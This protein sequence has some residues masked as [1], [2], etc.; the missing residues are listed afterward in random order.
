MNAPPLSTLGENALLA[1]LLPGLPRNAG[2]LTGPGD[3]CAVVARNAA[4]DGLLK[5]DALVEGIHF[6]PGTEPARIGHKA[7]AR[8]LSDIAAMGGLPE[9][10]LV[11]LF[12]HPSRPVSLIE[13]IYEGMAALARR[14]GVSLAGGET[15]SLPHDGL[16]LNIALTGRVERGRAI[17][18]SGGRPGDILC[19]SGCLGGS[20]E[21]GRHLDFEP[22]LALARALVDAGAAPRA[23]MDLSDG[24]A[25]DL[26][27]LARASG[28]GYALDRACLPL[29]PGCSIGQALGDGEDYELLMAFAPETARRLA[30]LSLPAAL[31]PI[32]K[33]CAGGS[34]PLAGG[35]QHF[36]PLRAK[37]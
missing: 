10:A 18:R 27:R 30:A 17:L 26:P 23:M 16:A 11:T 20:F 3:D 14:Y 31:T 6:T 12:V 35:W 1:R 9:H 21:S 5:V 28:C 36:Q 19:V 4:W 2:L 22:R 13:G 15:T 29:H 7:L 8:A 24:L 33:L 25:C 32:G 34:A 37:A